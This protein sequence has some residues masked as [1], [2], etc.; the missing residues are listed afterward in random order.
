MSEENK[1]LFRRFID[2]VINNKNVNALDKLIGANHIE[3]N[4]APA[5]RLKGHEKRSIA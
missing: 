2:E 5:T 1:P 3:H 4:P